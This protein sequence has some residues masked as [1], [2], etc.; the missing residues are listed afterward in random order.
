[1][2]RASHGRVGAGLDAAAAARASLAWAVEKAWLDSHGP[3]FP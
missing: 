2:D 3:V 1:M